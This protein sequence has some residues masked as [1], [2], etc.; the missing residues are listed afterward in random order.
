[1]RETKKRISDV[2]ERQ[3]GAENASESLIFSQI[4]QFFVTTKN[5]MTFWHWKQKTAK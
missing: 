3:R 2:A 1:M 4:T 5:T